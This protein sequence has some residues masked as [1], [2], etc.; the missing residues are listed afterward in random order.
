MKVKSQLTKDF[1]A[2]VL[3]K[4]GLQTLETT[5]EDGLVITDGWLSNWVIVYNNGKWACNN[6]FKV[7]KPIKNYLDL[8]AKD[9]RSIK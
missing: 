8:F 2:V 6:I 9:Y 3:I 5:K 1:E 7:N 4:S